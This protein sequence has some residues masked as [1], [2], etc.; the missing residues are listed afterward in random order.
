VLPGHRVPFRPGLLRMKTRVR[1]GT[2]GDADRP[3]SRL[4]GL[5]SMR[6]DGPD[7]PAV[8]IDSGRPGPGELA[9]ERPPGIER[10]VA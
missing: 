6:G 8:M 2:H 5:G 4:T 9:W 10:G 7:S 1:R 3:R